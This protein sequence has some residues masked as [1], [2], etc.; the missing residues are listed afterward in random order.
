MH[1][2]NAQFIKHQTDATLCCFIFPGGISKG[3]KN[4]GVFKAYTGWEGSENGF[5]VTL[6]L[7]LLSWLPLD[8]KSNAHEV[9]CLLQVSLDLRVLSIFLSKIQTNFRDIDKNKWCIS[10]SG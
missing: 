6:F 9:T 3:K 8:G 10:Q 4:L 1:R 7:F 2:A 5:P